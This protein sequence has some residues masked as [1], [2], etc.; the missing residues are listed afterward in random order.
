MKK[1]QT[2]FKFIRPMSNMRI[3]LLS[4][5]QGNCNPQSIADSTG[6]FVGQVRHALKNLCFIRAV[7]ADRDDLGRSMFIIPGSMVGVANN[8]KGVSSIFNCR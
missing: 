4:V 5:E 7:M 2:Q 6:L 8:L 1:G 3:V